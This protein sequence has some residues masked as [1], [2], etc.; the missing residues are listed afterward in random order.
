MSRPEVS[1]KLRPWL[2]HARRARGR[3]DFLV[4]RAAATEPL[5][6]NFGY[7]RGT[8]IDRFYIEGFLQEHSG[9]VGG[10]VLEIGSDDYSR[11]YGGG[12]ISRQDIL[13]LNSRAPR[14]TITGDLADEG[15]LEAHSF[16]CIIITQ[17][18]HLI[19]DSAAAVS[20]MRKALRPGGVALIT[21][22]AIS[23]ID[24][25]VW[26][27]SWYWPMTAPSLSRLLSADFDDIDVRS[28]GNLLAATAFLHGASVEE[29]GS[30][31]LKAV[32]PAYPI[33]IAARAV[34]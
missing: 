10:R 9:D 14:A 21:V 26:K 28:Y 32:D 4:G 8:P 23:P 20:Q 2:T 22:P 17:T 3:F 27:D 34:A 16:D 29:V 19:F 7:E 18:L 24:R 33:T 12:R 25:G 31:R 13:D 15:V 6:N 11:R 1:P 5:S 30:R